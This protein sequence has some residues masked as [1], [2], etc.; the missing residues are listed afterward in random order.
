MLLF[1]SFSTGKNP[2]VTVNRAAS[3][4]GAIELPYRPLPNST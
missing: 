2:Q 3:E 1:D 4:L